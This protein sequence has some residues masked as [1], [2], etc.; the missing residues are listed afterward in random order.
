MAGTVKMTRQFT[1]AAFR[2]YCEGKP[3][4]ESYD[5]IEAETC[6]ISQFGKEVLGIREV[7][8]SVWFDL[9][10]PKVELSREVNPIVNRVDGCCAEG[11]WTYGALVERLKGMR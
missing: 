2:K 11:P 4:D 9:L 1:V 3:A 8:D 10:Y 6:P 7:N 5:Y